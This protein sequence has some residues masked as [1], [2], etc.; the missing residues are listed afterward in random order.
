M[1]GSDEAVSG[2]AE[3]PAGGPILQRVGRPYAIEAV[4]LVESG[5]AGVLAIDTA[6]E[7]AG[8]RVGPLRRLDEIGLDV[9][10]AVDRSLTAR[11]PL[12]GRFDPPMLQLRLVEEGRCGR[13]AGRGFYRYRGTG[14]AGR[15]DATPD[16]DVTSV[17]GSSPHV[18]ATAAAERPASMIL[19]P[20]AIVERLE[21]A[22]VNEAYRVVEEG[23]GS[24]PAIDAIMRAAGF[25][26]G[27]F[28]LVDRTGLRQVVE[29]L[30]A[31]E[32]I[33]SARSGDQYRVATLLWQMATV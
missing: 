28:E 3:T 2:G 19:S 6:M 21:L 12:G 24:P 16:D 1:S 22:S 10:L 7:A 18:S 5:D 9:D 25:P 11:Y 20:E 4:R 29:R 33:T 26:L 15:A 8:Y 32:A 27:P 13:A 23:L 14:T 31:L 30:R 17:A